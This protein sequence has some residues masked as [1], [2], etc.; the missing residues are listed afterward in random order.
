M[1]EVKEVVCLFDMSGL[2]A[3]AWAKAGYAVHCY[4]KL[5]KDTQQVVGG[6]IIFFH[7]WD[8][9]DDGALQNLI[10]RHRGSCAFMMAFPP[11]TDLAVSGAAHFAKK[12]KADPAFQEKAMSL[13]FLARDLGEALGVP[14]FVENPISMVSTFW[15]KPDYIFD[16]WEFGGY[17]PENDVHPMFPEYIEPRDAYPK[18][19]CYWVGGGFTLPKKKR[20][21]PQPGYSKQHRKLGGKSMKT[22]IIRSLSPR[23]IARAIYL[24]H[25]GGGDE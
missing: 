13:V 21:F 11:C 20:V 19:T 22:K 12:R 18:K 8:A 16:P 25:A 1:S 3:Y 14:Y 2:A 6:G 7:S 23:G 15:R 5:N 17:L 4:D 24:A 10:S 9:L